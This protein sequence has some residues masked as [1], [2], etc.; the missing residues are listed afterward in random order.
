V[1]KEPADL[2]ILVQAAAASGDA[3]AARIVRDWLRRSALEDRSLDVPLRRVGA[4]A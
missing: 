2:R 3:E 1:Q 4:A